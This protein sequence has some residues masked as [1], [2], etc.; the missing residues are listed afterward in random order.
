MQALCQRVRIFDPI[1][2]G[3]SLL[4][5]S[6]FGFLKRYWVSHYIDIMTGFCCCHKG[7]TELSH[8]SMFDCQ[9]QEIRRKEKPMTCRW[10]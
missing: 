8:M 3:P 4:V 2:S 1:Y 9:L 6:H 7:W 10:Q 5:E